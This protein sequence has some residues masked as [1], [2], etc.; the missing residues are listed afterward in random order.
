MPTD[1]FAKT[2]L[3]P[4]ILRLAL[5]AVF[6]YHGLDKILPRANYW[7]TAWASEA[8][9]AQAK[10]PPSVLEKLR[11]VA[12]RERPVEDPKQS[13]A[14]RKAQSEAEKK[15]A[16]ERA[17]WVEVELG[18]A[19]SEAGVK[20]SEALEF[21]AAQLAVAWGEFIGGV[22]LLLG[23]LVR[24]AAAGLIIIQVGAIFTV[25]WTH[26]FS[27]TQGGYEYNIVLIAICLVVICLG[28]GPYSLSGLLR[29]QRRAKAPP[30][31]QPHEP[32][33]V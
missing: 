24:L 20:R 30:P 3:A 14:E 4:L 33:K 25:T 8:E 10:I 22:A 7:G 26:G 17:Y 11:T 31:A 28:S 18:R 6:I 12:T 13:E 9:K 27:V 2:T 1:A 29:A 16:R 19:Y 15:L 32:V 21:H 5:A 23:F